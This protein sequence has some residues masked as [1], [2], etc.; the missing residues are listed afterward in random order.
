[1]F[2][3]MVRYWFAIVLGMLLSLAAQTAGAQPP[4]PSATAPAPTASAAP[5]DA[6]L[7]ERIARLEEN[8]KARQEES[9]KMQETIDGF[10]A[11]IG[12]LL[13][14]FASVVGV[15]GGVFFWRLRKSIGEKHITQA[16]LDEVYKNDVARFTRLFRAQRDEIA[17]LV[18]AK[19]S[20][21]HLEGDD[22]NDV[23][24]IR[25]MLT[26]RGFT[27]TQATIADADLVVL[28]GIQKCEAMA[29]GE[30]P[31][32]LKKRPMPVVFYTGESRMKAHL[33]ADINELTL[34]VTANFPSTVITQVAAL[35]TLTQ[36][37]ESETA[38][39]SPA[40]AKTPA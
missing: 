16:I 11:R 35:A 27:N 12:G 39:A 38:Q 20:R 17:G 9:K 1:M 4:P 15:A 3:G 28:L 7:R 2:G 40:A 30:L 37:L 6:E 31:K 18:L 29:K 34:A 14:A 5:S 8:L 23:D 22:S 33:L 25:A 36:S 21:I 24:R 26:K 32:M 10:W 13:T 19:D